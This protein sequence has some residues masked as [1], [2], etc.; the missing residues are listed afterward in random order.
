MTTTTVS[1]AKSGI[2][3]TLDK[4]IEHGR[5][6][7]NKFVAKDIFYLLVDKAERR[8][9]QGHPALLMED[10]TLIVFRPNG[11]A[12]TLLAGKPPVKEEV[13]P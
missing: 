13:Q 8:R 11:H 5:L 4:A 10:G 6:N 12:V 1:Q 7:V 2:E 3:V 9:C